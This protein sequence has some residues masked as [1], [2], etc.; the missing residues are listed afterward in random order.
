MKNQCCQKNLSVIDFSN[1]QNLHLKKTYFFKL[2]EI[3]PDLFKKIN[4]KKKSCDFTVFFQFLWNFC[5]INNLNSIYFLINEPNHH[6]QYCL[7][8]LCVSMLTNSQSHIFPHH[9]VLCLLIVNMSHVSVFELG[10]RVLATKCNVED[11]VLVGFWV[12]DHRL[13]IK[14]SFL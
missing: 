7:V 11:L 1:R 2:I 14:K 4:Q 13:L 5:E 3:F 10:V 6:H 8:R 9:S 12:V